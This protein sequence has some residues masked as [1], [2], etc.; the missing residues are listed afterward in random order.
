MIINRQ[1][2]L[3]IILAMFFAACSQNI[4]NNYYEDYSVKQNITL[5]D[6]FYS[7]YPAQMFSPDAIYDTKLDIDRK[8][9]RLNSSHAQ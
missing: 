2:F 5:I 3:P 9:T 7:N 4:A 8:S 6:D 1:I